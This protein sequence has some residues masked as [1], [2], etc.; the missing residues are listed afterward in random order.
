M[1]IDMSHETFKPGAKAPVSAQ[2][3]E[4]GPKGGHLG[5]EA[6]VVKG[7]PLPPTSAP[8]HSWLPVDMTKH[9]SGR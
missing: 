5:N 2:Y 6:T 7:E 8:K 4:I 9:R 1:E 3:E